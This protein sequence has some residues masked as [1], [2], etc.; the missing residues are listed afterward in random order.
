MEIK[1]Y[2][3]ASEIWINC[4]DRMQAFIYSKVHDLELAEEINSQ[5]L[6]K[7]LD[8]CC[9]GKA[10]NHVSSWVHRIAY[11]TLIDELKKRSKHS[12]VDHE[13]ETTESRI[14]YKE[15]A[16]FIEPL[17]GFLPEKY[18]TPL[19]MADIEGIKQD[20]IAKRLGLSI[21]GAKSRIQRAR[22]LLKQEINTC[23]HLDQEN[24]TCLNGFQLK[25][26]CEP[27]QRHIEKE[28]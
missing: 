6:Q 7:L 1:S 20:E 4:K 11:N 26:T 14:T 10:I 27:L 24:P 5:V 8:S 18:A 23:F 19:V 9:S 17:I 2:Q 15:L 12:A 22:A 3:Q 28:S 25:A 13:L 21:S 16:E